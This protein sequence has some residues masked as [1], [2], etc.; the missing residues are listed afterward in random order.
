MKSSPTKSTVILK[1]LIERLALLKLE[2][3]GISID[4]FNERARRIP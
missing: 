1:N 2:S 4:T 3:L